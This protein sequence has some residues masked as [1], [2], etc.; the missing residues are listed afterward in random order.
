M[1]SGFPVTASA[2]AQCQ[3][4]WIL[5]P[6]SRQVT[7]WHW[8]WAATTRETWSWDS[9]M[10][11]PQGKAWVGWLAATVQH[12]RI[13]E[14]QWRQALH[15]SSQ[16]N[17]ESSRGPHPAPQQG[18]WGI[19]GKGSLCRTEGTCTGGGLWAEQGQQSQAPAQAAHHRQAGPPSAAVTS[20]ELVG[21]PRFSTAS[22]CGKRPSAGRR[23]NTHSRKTEQAGTL[24]A[25]APATWDQTLLLTG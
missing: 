14:E 24:K 4:D 2:C 23:V 13:N 17:T 18:M 20:Q 12:S 5:Q 8:I 1:A 6:C 9:E 19:W 10:T 25:S 21:L 7:A 3:A 15:H 22:I 11:Q 16:P